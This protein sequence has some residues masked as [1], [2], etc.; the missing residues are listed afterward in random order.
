MFRGTIFCRADGTASADRVR[1]LEMP[2]S[3][4]SAK[5]TVSLR[6]RK[7]AAISC[8]LVCSQRFTKGAPQY[9]ICHPERAKRVEGS[10][11]CRNICSQIG[12]KILRLRA[13]PS[14]QDDRGGRC[15]VLL[16]YAGGHPGW[17]A[18]AVPHTLQ[19]QISPRNDKFRGVMLCTYSSTPRNFFA[20]IPT[21]KDSTAT[22]VEISAISRKRRRKG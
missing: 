14:A 10:S 19:K 18:W 22:P 2:V 5:T 9:P 3:C 11:H 15:P 6:A 16:L 20:R 1:S 12:A 8:G 17:S 4:G 21:T 13:L 7:G